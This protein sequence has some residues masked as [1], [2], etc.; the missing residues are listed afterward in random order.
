MNQL[1]LFKTGVLAISLLLNLSATGQSNIIQNAQAIRTPDKEIIYDTEGYEVVQ[2]DYELSFDKKGFNQIRRKLKLPKETVLFDSPDFPNVKMMER[3][4][5]KDR[6]TY[7]YVYYLST[8]R[9]GILKV[10]SF[11]TNCSR[12]PLLEKEFYAEIIKKTLPASMYTSMNADTVL[13]AGR[14]IVADLPC[15]WMNIRNV[16]C[17]NYGQM[18]WSEFTDS[19]RAKQA[20]DNQKIENANLSTFGISGEVEVPVIFEGQEVTALKRTMVAI[21]TQA[22]ISRMGRSNVLIVYY[23]LAKVRNRYVSCVL[24]HYTDDVGV[25]ENKLPPLLTEVMQL[26]E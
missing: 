15:Q 25:K 9:W 11:A 8:P 2:K 1:I 10:V 21:A 18:N 4:L 14:P 24:S 3:N 13:F 23:V 6:I 22:D 5:I 7:H 12:L 20:L 17:R 26:K 16:Q 19:I